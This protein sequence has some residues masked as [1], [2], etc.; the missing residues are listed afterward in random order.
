[1]GDF[2]IL[3][4][5]IDLQEFNGPIRMKASRIRNV[6]SLLENYSAALSFFKI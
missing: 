6:E 4:V 3:V 1:M 2:L 5:M